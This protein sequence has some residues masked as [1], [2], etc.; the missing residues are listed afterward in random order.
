MPDFRSANAWLPIACSTE[1][2]SL[3]SCTSG[4]S[5]SARNPLGSAHGE[6]RP[7]EANASFGSNLFSQSSVMMPCLAAVVND[8]ASAERSF[9]ACSPSSLLPLENPLRACRDSAATPDGPSAAY[10]PLT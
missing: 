8:V 2:G 6:Y 4:I 5:R 9:S 3:P 1:V 7:S 10:K